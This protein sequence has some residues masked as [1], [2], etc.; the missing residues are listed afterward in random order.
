MKCAEGSANFGRPRESRVNASS[1]RM[2]ALWF[3]ALIWPMMFSAVSAQTCV[4]GIVAINPTAQYAIANGTAADQR[5]GLMW[6]QCTWGQGGAACA[7]GAAGTLSWQLALGVPA[8]ANA[9][10]YKGYS[11]WRLPNIKELRSLVEVCRKAPTI[12]D[13]VFPNTSGL[14]YLSSLFWSSS[15]SANYPDSAWIVNFNYGA[16]WDFEPRGAQFRIRLVRAGR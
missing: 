15:P 1:L 9:S 10:Q 8:V 16:S 14:D 12:N 5:T 6:D 3:L 13:I 11:D 7:S 4:A 2:N